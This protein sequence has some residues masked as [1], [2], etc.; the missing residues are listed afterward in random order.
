MP[1]YLGQCVHSFLC[2]WRNV[3]ASDRR[4]RGP[5]DC[6]ANSNRIVAACCSF[7]QSDDILCDSP[8]DTR[9]RHGLRSHP[10][11]DSP[12]G[13]GR[14]SEEHTSE[15]QS[16]DHL[17]CRLLLEKKKKTLYHHTSPHLTLTPPSSPSHT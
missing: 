9:D 17:V 16:P 3:P 4:D 11:C 2:L 8:G 7:Q 13:C 12:C 1:R 6:A 10:N 14:R 5:D 15:L